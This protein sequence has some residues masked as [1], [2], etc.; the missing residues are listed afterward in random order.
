[1]QGG[2]SEDCY[3]SDEFSRSC[4]SLN[5]TTLKDLNI[6]TLNAEKRCTS[7]HI[8]ANCQRLSDV[9]TDTVKV[10]A[11]LPR[12]PHKLSDRPVEQVDIPEDAAAQARLT[13]QN[14]SSRFPVSFKALNL[15]ALKSLN[16]TELLE[17]DVISKLQ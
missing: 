7:L 14:K 9:S 11:G 5:A 17:K 2:R 12:L 15:E 3:S 6:S 1:M 4:T 10:A 16:E 13:A 8:A